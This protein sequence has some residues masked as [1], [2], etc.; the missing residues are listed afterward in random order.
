MISYLLE[1]VSRFKRDVFLIANSQ[2]QVQIYINEIDYT[3]ISAFI[4]DDYEISKKQKSSS[5]LIGLY[6][7]FK[8]L[9]KLGYQKVFVLSC[10]NPLV[11]FEVIEYIT[12]HCE[13]FDCCIPKWN[14]NFLEPLLAIYPIGKAYE[15]SSLN[16]KNN[17]FKLTK[18]VSQT[19][20]TNF[21]SIEEEIMLL[22]KK[23]QSFININTKEDIFNLKL[24]V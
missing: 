21:I 18:L 10:D 7:A 17:I 15:I 23:L 14:N 20:K 24:D 12:K 22:D 9:K 2:Q 4:V 11:K 13:G 3:K 16:L 8:E 19:W 5:P 6:T 1:T